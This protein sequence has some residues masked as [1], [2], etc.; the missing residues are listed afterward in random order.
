MVFA[1]YAAQGQRGWLGGERGR[2]KV[3][4]GAWGWIIGQKRKEGRAGLRHFALEGDVM[5]CGRRY[6]EHT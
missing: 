4:L 6:G 5:D 2:K 1:G 3:H